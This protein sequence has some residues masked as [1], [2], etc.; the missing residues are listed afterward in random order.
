[1]IE[2]IKKE[3]ENRASYLKESK[4]LEGIFIEEATSILDDIEPAL[5]SLENDRTNLEILKTISRG[6][7]TLKGSSGCL[8]NN[9]ITKYVHKYEDLVSALQ[10]NTLNLTDD[11]YDI[12]F[13][14]FD[15]IK[16]LINSISNKKL[17]NYNIDLLL[18]EVT[19]DLNKNKVDKQENI[20]KEN[21]KN[22]DHQVQKL[23]DNIAVPIYMLDELSG[24][25][26]EITVIRNMVNK[27]IPKNEVNLKKAMK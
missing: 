2:V 5:L 1:M 10:K 25:S 11:I 20:N 13:K 14:G 23:K 6:A 17:N 12:L 8:T 22:N 9:I 27:I 26:G 24:F 3:S 15:R 21:N 19:I 7:H 16:E 4:I 18:P